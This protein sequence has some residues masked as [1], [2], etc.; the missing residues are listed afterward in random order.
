MYLFEP[1]FPCLFNGGSDHWSTYFTS[2]NQI[3]MRIKWGNEQKKAL[4]T[5]TWN[6]KKSILKG[7][8]RICSDGL[9]KMQTIRKGAIWRQ[10]KNSHGRKMGRNIRGRTFVVE[11]TSSKD[12]LT[13]SPPC[14]KP[15]NREPLSGG[16]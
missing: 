11:S 4:I 3:I 10:R 8:W 6:K 13:P 1:Q 9:Q 15:N 2:V 7:A 16:L 12:Y 14:Y 5:A